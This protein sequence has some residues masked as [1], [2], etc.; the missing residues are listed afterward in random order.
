MI[1]TLLFIVLPY[2]AVVLCIFG[3]IYR[4]RKAPMTYS[5]LSSQFLESK[6]LM[7]GLTTLAHW[8]HNNLISPLRGLCRTRFLA[9]HSSLAHCL[10]HH[11]INRDELIRPLP[12]WTPNPDDK[13]T[14]LS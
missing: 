5:A 9:K 3:S 13:E 8:H 10:D 1:D 2:L 6:G 11:R 7:W 14:N 4:V 12:L